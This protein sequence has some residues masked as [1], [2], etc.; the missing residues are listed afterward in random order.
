MKYFWK[1][2][3]LGLQK[4]KVIDIFFAEGISNSLSEFKFDPD[5]GST[6]LAYFRW[7]EAIFTKRC[8]Q[9]PDEEK[10]ITISSEDTKYAN[11]ILPK[12]PEEITFSKTVENFVENF[13]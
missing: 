6:F 13:W 10:K 2:F 5:S 11:R 3:H 7:Y 8:E 4:N 12:K 9:L 1:V